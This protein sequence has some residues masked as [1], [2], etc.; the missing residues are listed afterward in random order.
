LLLAI[1]ISFA[2]TD[3]HIITDYDITPCDSLPRQVTIEIVDSNSLCIPP[4]HIFI[5]NID[6]ILYSAPIVLSL[7]TGLHTV[8]VGCYGLMHFLDIYIH[9]GFTLIQDYGIDNNFFLFILTHQM[10]I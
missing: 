1:T 10:T 5:D 6:T 4:Y 9:C 8:T 7:D 2:Q 3:L